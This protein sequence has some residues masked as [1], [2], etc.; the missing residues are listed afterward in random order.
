MKLALKRAL[1]TAFEAPP[2]ARKREFLRALSGRPISFVQFVASQ[3]AYIGKWTFAVSLLIFGAALAATRMVS[4]DSLWMLSCLTPFLAVCAVAEN[5][6][7]KTCQIAELE[8][9]SRFSL[10]S[11]A[12]ARMFVLGGA[13][14]RLLCLLVLL[15]RRAGAATVFETG[16]Y[17]ITPYLLTTAGGLWMVRRMKGR[18]TAYACM[19]VAVMVS[20]LLAVAR[21]VLPLY[22]GMC[23]PWWVAAFVLLGFLSALEYR[24]TLL[25]T[26]D[27]LWNWL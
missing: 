3:A 11:V 18:E 26:E 10:R 25:K 23:Y 7:S 1:Q 9:A 21:T 4:K 12:L 2:P 5:T 22:Q 8:M 24:K 6:K 27:C 13:H 15:G 14:A 16:I 19:G 20:A 17:L